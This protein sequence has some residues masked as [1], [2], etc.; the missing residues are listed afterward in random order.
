[1]KQR[2]AVAHSTLRDG[3]GRPGGRAWQGMRG[4]AGERQA[5]ARP[6]CQGRRTG[7]SSCQL[8]SCSSSSSSSLSA[9]GAS[10][11]LG[12]PPP[13][14]ELEGTP[15]SRPPAPAPALINR[16]GL[17]FAGIWSRIALGW[18]PWEGPWATGRRARGCG[19]ALAGQLCVTTRSIGATITWMPSVVCKPANSRPTSLQERGGSGERFRSRFVASPF[20]HLIQ[21]VP[22]HSAGSHGRRAAQAGGGAAA[23]GVPGGG[24]PGVRGHRLGSGGQVRAGGRGAAP[25][26]TIRLRCAAHGSDRLTRDCPMGR[27]SKDVRPQYPNL[28]V[29]TRIKSLEVRRRPAAGRRERSVTQCQQPRVMGGSL[30][31]ALG[32]W[33]ARQPAKHTSCLARAGKTA[34]PRPGQ[35]SQ[36]RPPLVHCRASR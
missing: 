27:R 34:T 6:A 9:S 28:D 33:G 15:L 29:P 4:S 8:S 30:W 12:P 18:R 1:M 23:R 3:G 14:S 32:P 19:D 36:N 21:S 26:P 5:A 24:G 11:L 13:G 22:H 25:R 10:G 2:N 17:C 35:P 31:S 7:S 16:A 20:A